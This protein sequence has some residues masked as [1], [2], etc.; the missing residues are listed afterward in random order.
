MNIPN[1]WLA[2][3]FCLLAGVIIL[4]FWPHHGR[5]S[6]PSR[7]VGA[8]SVQTSR[9]KVIPT[10]NTP[11]PQRGAVQP[12]TADFA[13]NT[14]GLSQKPVEVRMKFAAELET[15]SSDD[16]L[17]L[18]LAEA[19]ARN[20]S[21]KLDFIA[22]ALA[23][24]LR[25][26]QTDPSTVL[27]RMQEFF[28]DSNNDQYSRWQI[29]QILGQT[30]TRETLAALLSLLGSTEQPEPRA[31]LLEQVAKASQNNWAGHFHEDFTDLLGSGWLSATAQSDS[32]TVLGFSIASVGSQQALE[33][34][35]SQIKSGGQ[36]VREFEQKADDKAW[37]AF[38]SLE[39]VRNPAALSFLN[40]ELSTGP[41]D[42]ITTSAA[43]YCLAKMGQPEATAILLRYVQRSPADVSG[44]VADWFALMRDGS[45]VELAN[46][47]IKQAEF[48]NQQ[49]KG[50]LSA[51]LS[52]WLAYRSENLRP[53]V[54]R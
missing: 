19:K 40:S 45:S 50:A 54:D 44:Y 27:R 12:P 3:G 2:T 41:P 25:D 30:A 31:W 14:E 15:K 13:E 5:D 28:S 29:A 16:L 34:L 24:G 39:Q 46:T 4:A 42:S 43:G 32:L 17:D 52:V 26:A 23:T 22:D 8:T 10:R 33:L 38:G 11:L 9:Q 20:D 35:F 36:T 1:R 48:A 6:S 37:V 18:W 51:A 21:L 49:N 7:E 47:A 53:I